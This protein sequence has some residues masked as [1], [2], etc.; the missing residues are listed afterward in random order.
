MKN[1]TIITFVCSFLIFAI[2]LFRIVTEAHSSTSLFVAYIFVI[3]GF[4]GMVAN[5]LM[6]RK[7][8]NS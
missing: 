5:G 7:S 8:K 3:A 6:L 1:R 2:G 4:I